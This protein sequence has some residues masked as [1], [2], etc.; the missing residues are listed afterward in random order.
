MR[1]HVGVHEFLERGGEF[2]VGA[3]QGRR[4]HPVDEHG[5]VGES[6]N[7]HQKGTAQQETLDKL[8]NLLLSENS[9]AVRGD[10]PPII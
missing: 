5:T 10:G 2:L 9:G 8:H 3:S 6:G 1:G 7:R 4:V